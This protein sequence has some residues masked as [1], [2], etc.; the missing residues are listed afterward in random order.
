MFNKKNDPLVESVKAVMK[1]N[2]VHRQIEAALN[3]ELGISSKRALPHEYHA[4]YDALLEAKVVDA[5]K[6]IANSIPSKF[7]N[8]MDKLTGNKG[9]ASPKAPKA[10]EDPY[11]K[12]LRRRKDHYTLE[13]KSMN[14]SEIPSHKELIAAHKSYFE[15]EEMN[16]SSQEIKK[17]AGDMHKALSNPDHP[18]HS[19]AKKALRQIMAESVIAEIRE[20]LEAKQMNEIFKIVQAAVAGR[21]A[22][23]G[24]GRS[25]AAATGAGKG[26]AGV[27]PAGAS[28]SS[29]LAGGGNP[30]TALVPYKPQLPAA[31]VPS[32]PSSTALVPRTPSAQSTSGA[33]A[34]KGAA[35]FGAGTLLSKVPGPIEVEPVGKTAPGPDSDAERAS[36][37]GGLT[38]PPAAPAAPA[39]TPAAPAA[40]P[41][42]RQARQAPVAKPDKPA[43]DSTWAQRVT[44][45]ER[46]GRS[47]TSKGPEEKNPFASIS[48]SVI[49]EIRENLEANLMAI[50]ESGDDELFENYV[51]SL[52]EEELEILG[53]SEDWRANAFGDNTSGGSLSNAGYRTPPSVAAAQ[54]RGAAGPQARPAPTAARPATPAAAKTGPTPKATVNTDGPTGSGT[55]KPYRQGT[56]KFGPEKPDTI[57]QFEPQARPRSMA[58]QVTAGSEVGASKQ[59][60]VPDTRTGSDREDITPPQEKR[61]TSGA[62]ARAA[63]SADTVG[64]IQPGETGTGSTGRPTSDVVTTVPTEKPNKKD[65]LNEQV[66]PNDNRSLQIKES[67]ESF[68]RNRFLKG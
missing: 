7:R 62:F 4:Q 5:E 60:G 6:S 37:G 58:P 48:E 50:H 44:T 53:L 49:A 36:P 65:P 51:N 19:N 23:T 9:G 20:N 55:E 26:A 41:A 15:R 27:P 66:K 40:T 16:R 34:G 24:A 47:F 18:D 8:V 45:A 54:A 12:Q 13:E 2:E 32:K 61:G 10:K 29:G 17:A 11:K 33:G 67:L 64:Q 31:V 63:K 25:A 46:G 3:E 38:P 22:A 43:D 21:I 52:T 56:E 35:G 1:Q 59:A 68:V 57:K 30:S 39:A 42:P 28:G 14:E